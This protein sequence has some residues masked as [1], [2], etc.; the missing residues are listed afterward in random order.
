MGSSTSPPV[1]HLVHAV[2]LMCGDILLKELPGMSLSFQEEDAD[3]RVR[4]S[5]LTRRDAHRA[6]PP[7]IKQTA[8][9]KCEEDNKATF[10]QKAQLISTSS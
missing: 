2:C 8:C 10:M 5:A 4:F 7:H 3:G 6:G 9:T 1:S